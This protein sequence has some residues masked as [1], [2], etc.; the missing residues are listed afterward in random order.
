[1]SA[2]TYSAMTVS[3][4]CN[5]ASI[6]TFVVNPV[7]S[8]TLC[9]GGATCPSTTPGQ[10][11][12]QTVTVSGGT[13]TSTCAITAGTLSGS[14]LTLNSNC[15]ITGTAAAI[16]T[17]TFTVTATDANSISGAGT[18]FTLSIIAACA[19]PSIIAFDKAT[20]G[21]WNGNTTSSLSWSHQILSTSTPLLAVCF[22]GDAIGGNDDIT[23]VQYGGVSMVLAAK[24]TSNSPKNNN[25]IT[26][27][28][29]LPNAPSGT[30]TVSITANSVHSLAAVSVSY[31][32]AAIAGQPDAASDF[33]ASASS[34]FS[35][36][37]STVATNAWMLLCEGGSP[38]SSGGAG[39]GSTFRLTEGAAGEAAF[40][41]SNAAITPPASYSMATNSNVGVADDIH[42]MASI[43][44]YVPGTC[45][46]PVVGAVTPGAVTR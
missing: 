16:A 39:A 2:G 44:P 33:S 8:V 23:S 12:S 41:D 15:T 29:L 22:A 4:T 46:V 14:G 25:H 35:T 1:M 31:S 28:Y 32:G 13:G 43:S 7:P 34:P 11:Y 40:F 20:D 5:T 10:S 17:Y 21:G 26:Y 6:S 9:G 38:L 30:N 24:H 37:L 45:P 19:V 3:D 36:S 27:L 18:Q 42:I